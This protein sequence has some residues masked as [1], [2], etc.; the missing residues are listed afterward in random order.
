VDR[1]SRLP[2]S[3]TWLILRSTQHRHHSTCP[4]NCYMHGLPTA[5][6][7]ML[8]HANRSVAHKTSVHH[9]PLHALR[10]YPLYRSVHKHSHIWDY[11]CLVW[12]NEKMSTFTEILIAVTD[13]M[14]MRHT[15]HTL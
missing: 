8:F 14:C 10:C 3:M 7:P 5:T 1:H 12:C 11:R 9:F 4:P 15:P 13:I 6:V 2:S